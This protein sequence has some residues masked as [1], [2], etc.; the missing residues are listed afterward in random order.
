RD[1]RD[2]LYDLAI[3]ESVR[4]TSLDAAR[5]EF[6]EKVWYAAD[7]RFLGHVRPGTYDIV[8]SRGMEYDLHIETVDMVSGDHIQR[9]VTLRRSVDTDGWIAAD[10]HLHAQG[11]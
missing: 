2:F 9:S 11:S 5:N 4:H 7:G 3:G 8:V 1:P 6:V 10:L